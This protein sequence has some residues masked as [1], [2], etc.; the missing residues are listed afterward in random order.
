MAVITM[1][2]EMGSRGRDVAL[3]VAERLGLEV[4]HD[5]LVEHHLAEQ[6][7]VTESQVHRFLEG[8]GSLWD[9]W[10]INRSRLFRHTAVQILEIAAAGHVL[11]RGWGATQLLRGC[12][13]VLRVRVC[14]PMRFREDVLMARLAIDDRELAR[15]EIERNDAAHQSVVRKFF[16]DDWRKPENYDMVLNTERMPIDVCVQH[17]VLTAQDPVF[18]ESGHSRAMLVNKLSEIRNEEATARLLRPTYSERQ[19]EARAERKSRT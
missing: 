19:R 15:Q 1:T 8:G 12:A 2:R 6:M 16:K 9:R 5:E 13:G 7:N 3:G 10:R 11:I 18:Q 14:A 4:I 17:L